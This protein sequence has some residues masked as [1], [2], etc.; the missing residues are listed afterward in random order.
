MTAYPK[1]T[2]SSPFNINNVNRD[3]VKC[4]VPAPPEHKH[5]KGG[6]CGSGE[7]LSRMLPVEAKLGANP[8][9]SISL[10]TRK[11]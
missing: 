4:I 5:N 7:L 2:P 1:L 10:V 6:N 8:Q 9:G 3:E 11:V